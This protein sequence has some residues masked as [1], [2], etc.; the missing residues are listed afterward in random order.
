MA[1]YGQ[2]RRFNA[3]TVVLL[4][5][6]GAFGYWMWRFFPVY[7]DAW[8]VDHILREGAASTYLIN[9]LG[10]PA[11]TTALKGVVDKARLEVV[12]RVGIHDPEL[13]VD[14]N[15]DDDRATMSA[16]YSVVV[17]HPWVDYRS[18]MHLHRERAANIANVKWDK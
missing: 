7:F 1:T 5:G 3:L 13:R 14:L 15:I 2:P 10:E 9:R 17:T 8:S 11:R 4:L 16:D 12:G 18:T 6:A